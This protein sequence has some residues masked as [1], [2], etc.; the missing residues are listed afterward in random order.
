MKPVLQGLIP[1][2]ERHFNR[3]EKLLRQSYLIDFTLTE[4]KMIRDKMS[5]NIEKKF[6]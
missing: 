5:D 3:I 1:Y 6:G 4:M 2:T